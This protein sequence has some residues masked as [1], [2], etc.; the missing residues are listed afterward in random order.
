VRGNLERFRKDQATRQ[1][2]NQIGGML[3]K[4][5]IV[6]KDKC[7]KKLL[8]APVSRTPPAFEKRH[9]KTPME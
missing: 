7:G 9:K 3:K 8:A 2:E 4:I 6:Y 5:P 1:P